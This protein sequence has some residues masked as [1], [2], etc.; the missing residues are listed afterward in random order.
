[1]GH[2]LMGDEYDMPNEKIP[3]SRL[4]QRLFKTSS[5]SEFIQD[6]TNQMHHKRFDALLVDL[7]G[8]KNAV[9]EHVIRKSGIERTYGHQLFN[10]RRN[11]SRDKV[12]QLAF[13]FEMSFEETQS[14]LQAAR[15]SPLYPRIKR[16]AVLIYALKQSYTMDEVQETLHELGLPLLGKEGH[17]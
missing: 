16:D 9:P 11:P 7:C 4:L 2:F 15:K 13:G 6:Y 1:M 5:I 14:F 12:L 17:S 10:G 8:R 3:T